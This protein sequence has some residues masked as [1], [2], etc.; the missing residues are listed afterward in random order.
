MCPDWLKYASILCHHPFAVHLYPAK[1]DPALISFNPTPGSQS[2]LPGPS[3]FPL[4]ENIIISRFSTFMLPASSCLKPAPAFGDREADGRTGYDPAAE[5]ASRPGWG[6]RTATGYRR[7]LLLTTCMKT[8][9]LQLRW[10]PTQRERQELSQLST[11][12]AQAQYPQFG[13]LA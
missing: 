2:F 13:N 8:L 7:K 9:T 11:I 3:W 1:Q 10:T 4:P 6:A 12:L 5:T